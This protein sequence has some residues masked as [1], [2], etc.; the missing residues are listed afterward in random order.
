MNPENRRQE[1]ERV[2]ESE[3]VS[4]QHILISIFGREIE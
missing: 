3:I 1:V 4:N 2:A